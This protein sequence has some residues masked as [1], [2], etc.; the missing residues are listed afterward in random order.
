MKKCLN[1]ATLKWIAMLSMLIDHFTAVFFEASVYNGPIIFSYKTYVFLRGV[2]RLAFPIYCFLL[3]AGF[4]FSLASSAASHRVFLYVFGLGFVA[5]EIYY[6]AGRK[7][8]QAI[9]AEG[10]ADADRWHAEH[11]D[12]FFFVEVTDYAPHLVNELLKILRSGQAETL[13][14]ALNVYD[15]RFQN[16]DDSSCGKS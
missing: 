7:K 10:N 8:R 9:I 6:R 15:G 11:A 14:G 4:L 12:D 2:G 13:K 3:V 1:G 5:N 16:E